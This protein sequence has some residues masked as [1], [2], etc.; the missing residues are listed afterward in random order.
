METSDREQTVGS[1]IHRALQNP[2]SNGDREEARKPRFN[3]EI[4]LGHIL[5]ILAL[6]GSMTMVWMKGR[7]TD[8]GHEFRLNRVEGD[9]AEM[10]KTMTQLADT[11]A[12]AVRNQEKLTWTIDQ[13]SGKANRNDK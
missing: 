5:T 4:N 12:L 3:G 6:M 7:E 13:L 2:H 11:Q 8:L 1:T 9:V 10:R